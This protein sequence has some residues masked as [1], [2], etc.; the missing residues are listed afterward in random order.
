MYYFIAKRFTTPAELSFGEFI[1]FQ[2]VIFILGLF[3]NL[4][5]KPL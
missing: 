1:I 2:T 3:Q 4:N 5:L